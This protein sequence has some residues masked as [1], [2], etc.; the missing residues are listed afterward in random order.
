MRGPLPYFGAGVPVESHWDS[1]TSRSLEKWMGDTGEGTVVRLEGLAGWGKTTVMQIAARE[2]KTLLVRVPGDENGFVNELILKCSRKVFDLGNGG[3]NVTVG[4]VMEHLKPLV[5]TSFWTLLYTAAASVSAARESQA[6]PEI[7]L[8]SSREVFATHPVSE[9]FRLPLSSNDRLVLM[10][11]N[12]ECLETRKHSS[13][14]EPKATAVLEDWGVYTFV[15]L[16]LEVAR[17]YALNPRLRVA[18]SLNQMDGAEHLP[19]MDDAPSLFPR[20][21]SLRLFPVPFPSLPSSHQVLRVLQRYLGGDRK[22][23]GV[24]LDSLAKQ[25]VGPPRILKQL[26]VLVRPSA[27]EPVTAAEVE[28]A[29]LELE[30]THHREVI[31]TLSLCSPWQTPLLEA[32]CNVWKALK[33]TR[34][35]EPNAASCFTLPEPPPPGW[36]MVERSGIL[37]CRE[38]KEGGLV[39]PVYH[40]LAT[41]LQSLEDVPYGS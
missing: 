28:T 24:C 31:D 3:E 38:G 12:M 40:F 35:L 9:A 29:L 2:A 5:A 1:P 10:F 30:D 11:D 39:V 14:L 26:L 13:P 27:D 33:A 17:A 15:S 16:A 4:D 22:S 6:Q 8:L 18:F 19:L 21:V 41:L 23:P 37:T 25:L 7:L 32:V 34:K 36:N 20:G